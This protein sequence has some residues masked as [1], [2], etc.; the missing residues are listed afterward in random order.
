MIELP[1]MF[2][3]QC[4]IFGISLYFWIQSWIRFYI[5]MSLANKIINF[6]LSFIFL[7]AMLTIGFYW[8]DTIQTNNTFF[9]KP[10]HKLIELQVK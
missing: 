6:L 7:F 10:V 1:Y 8:W 3:M 2:L 4:V 9:S 5:S